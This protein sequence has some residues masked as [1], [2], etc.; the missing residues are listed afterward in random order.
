MFWVSK[1]DSNETHIV[2]LVIDFLDMSIVIKL[3]FL[4]I[5]FLKLL[6]VYD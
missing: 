2:H 3:Y 1:R 5:K 6:K 4:H